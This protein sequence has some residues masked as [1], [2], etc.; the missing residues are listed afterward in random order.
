MKVTGKIFINYRRDDSA[1]YAVTIAQYLETAFGKD[2]VFLDIDRL[3][4]GEHFP[5]VLNERLR[6]C[7][8]M[9]AL[10]GPTWLDGRDEATG[11]R[12]IDDPYDWVRVE[13]VAALAQGVHVIVVFACWLAL[14]VMA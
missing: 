6:D 14:W 8:V 7:K 12:R 11:D 10:I 2:N 13:I 5:D 1:P 4:P 9:L 3:R